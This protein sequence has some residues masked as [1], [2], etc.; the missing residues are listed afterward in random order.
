MTP[1]WLQGLSLRRTLLVVLGAGIGVV[2]AAELVVASRSAVSAADAAYDRSL[3]GAIKSIDANISTASGGLGVEVQFRM[4]E[5]FQLTADGRVF[6][7]VATED[8]LVEIGDPALPAPKSP[9][10][11]GSPRFEN[12]TYFDTPVRLGSYARMLDRP[13]AGQAAPQRVI[14]QVAET[15]TSRKEFTGK[16]LRQALWRDLAVLAAALLLLVA[17]VNWALRPLARVRSEVGSRSPEDLAPIA[18]GA[19]P[20]DVRP[21]VEAI[22]HHVERTRAVMEERRRF[23]DDASHQLRT[24]LT[25]LATQL[26]FAARE[27]EPQ[28]LR[29]A[30]G[31]A[32][33]QLDEAIRQI[34]QLLALGRADSVEL[35]LEPLELGALAEEVTR[36]W[37]AEARRSRIDL[38]FEPAP[39]PVPV[40][41]FAPLLRE[42]VGNLLHNALRFTPAG[43]EV[44]VRVRSD[45]GQAR[46]LVE[47]NGPGIPPQHLPR[48]GERFYRAGNTTVSGSGLGLAIARSVAQR[49][50]GRLQIGPRGAGPG[51]AAAIVLPLDGNS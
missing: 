5:F 48:V 2:L 29:E 27:S 43:G 19:I 40:R 14:I 34:N 31:A 49:H 51:L 17:G 46:I 18:T 21:L 39:G 11:T 35:V 41:A 22:N 16:L 37:W 50:G 13:I 23:L 15:L 45:H 26:A 9:L 30:V 8:G 6:Y 36:A 24:P 33:R 12:T 32:R 4:L 47:D 42:A 7:R 25:T 20:A 10:V 28:Q 44:T 3:L 1:A 38:G